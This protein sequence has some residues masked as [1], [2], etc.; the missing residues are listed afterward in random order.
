MHRDTLQD[1]FAQYKNHNVYIYFPANQKFPKHLVLRLMLDC[2]R[3]FCYEESELCIVDLPFLSFS[4]STDLGDRAVFG[5][6][7]I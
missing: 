6:F 2:A 3:K 7:N 1:S 4:F 5:R